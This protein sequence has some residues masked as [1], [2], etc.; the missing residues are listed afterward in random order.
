MIRLIFLLALILSC[1]STAL[2]AEGL[3]SHSSPNLEIRNIPI[4]TDNNT[5]QTYHFG[6]SVLGMPDEDGFVPFMAIAIRYLDSGENQWMAVWNLNRGETSFVANLK[7]LVPNLW[8]TLGDRSEDDVE[9]VIGD[10]PEPYLVWT[11]KRRG[12]WKEVGWSSVKTANRVINWVNPFHFLVE[13]YTHYRA[14]KKERLFH[15]TYTL[16]RLYE[17]AMAISSSSLNLSPKSLLDLKYRMIVNRSTFG[18]FLEEENAFSIVQR[19]ESSMREKMSSV[20]CYAHVKA[21]EL[22]LGIEEINYGLPGRPPVCRAALIYLRGADLEQERRPWP[23]NN[24][25]DLSFDPF[26]HPRVQELAQQDP[27]EQIPL[28]IYI[29]GSENRMKPALVVDFFNPGNPLRRRATGTMK[30]ALD[31]FLAVQGLPLLGKIAKGTVEYCL[32]KKDVSYFDATSV[33][34]GIEA[35]RLFARMGWNLDSDTN[36]LLMRSMDRQ[37]GNP[38]V[39]SSFREKQNLNR[40]LGSIL[41]SDGGEL[42]LFL[43]TVFEDHIRN[44]M[45][46]GNKAVFE[47]D[48][49][50]YQD[51]LEYLEALETLKAFNNEPHLPGI[52]WG[53]VI[54]AWE[55]VSESGNEA[56]EE[57]ERFYARMASLFP[58]NVPDS[59]QPLVAQALGKDRKHAV[60][61]YKQAVPASAK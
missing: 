54:A 12:A 21:N 15:Q 50:A 48:L 30:V 11:A 51:R 56:P 29:L 20:S 40:N 18:L 8:G 36:D 14:D 60:L 41:Q 16:L 6:L 3:V 13:N 22:G 52:A 35:A 46:L 55:R 59:Y 24:F 9:E 53:E 23:A 42:R 45:D 1:L 17:E 38:L 28:G 4:W 32:D 19:F 10:F 2:S 7:A 47:A 5:S 43:R 49:L 37:A 26:E 31:H 25:F 58:Q 57:L 61:A 33:A 39:E 44:V 27:E 34:V